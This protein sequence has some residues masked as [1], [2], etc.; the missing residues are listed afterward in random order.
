M[1][2]VKRSGYVVKLRIPIVQSR[3]FDMNFA[4]VQRIKKTS[5]KPKKT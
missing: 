5:K 2:T 3:C 1:H 4:K